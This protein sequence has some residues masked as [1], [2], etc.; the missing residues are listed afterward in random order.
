[1][2]EMGLR[3]HQEQGDWSAGAAASG[4]PPES[5]ARAEHVDDVL[6]PGKYVANKQKDYILGED[7]KLSD[8]MQTAMF[9][10]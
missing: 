6:D 2:I 10:F 9:V 3:V 5:T 1:M 8:G 7:E 4:R